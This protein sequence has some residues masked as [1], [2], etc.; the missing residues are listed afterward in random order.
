M[1]PDL[2]FATLPDLQRTISMKGRA[3]L[4]AALRPAIVLQR[5]TAN[6]EIHL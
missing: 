1:I 6:V 2:A 4:R 3:A 5:D